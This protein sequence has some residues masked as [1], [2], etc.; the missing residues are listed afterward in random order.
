MLFL[1]VIGLVWATDVYQ[2]ESASGT[3]VFTD[4]PEHGGFELLI[5]DRKPLPKRSRVNKRTFPLLDTWDNTILAVSGATG[6]QA[7]LIK[8]VAVAES[9]MRSALK[10]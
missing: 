2:S 7:E 10:P 5:L 6:V 8:A 9:G 3:M 1:T 4:S